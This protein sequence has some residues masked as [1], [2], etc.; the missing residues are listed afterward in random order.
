MV[1]INK[2]GAS[3]AIKC[4][5]NCCYRIHFDKSNWINQMIIQ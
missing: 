3:K 2:V 4:V 5:N 1:W